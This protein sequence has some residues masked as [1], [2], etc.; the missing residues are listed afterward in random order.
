MAW[1][2]CLTNNGNGGGIEM[3]LLWTNPNPLAGFGEQTIP[4]DLSQYEYVAIDGSID[5]AFSPPYPTSGFAITPVGGFGGLCTGVYRFKSDG[6]T[7]CR[8]YDVL[9][10]GVQFYNGSASGAGQSSAYAIP[11]NIYGIKNLSLI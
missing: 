10:T 3:T 4:I 2:K 1:H 8:C 9:T 5:S 11:K 7:E 6:T